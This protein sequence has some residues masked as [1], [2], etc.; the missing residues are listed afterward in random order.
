MS[1]SHGC[2]F[3]S[4]II[5]YDVYHNSNGCEDSCPFYVSIYQGVESFIASSFFEQNIA[6]AS[7]PWPSDFENRHFLVRS[8]VIILNTWHS[9]L[10]TPKILRSAFCKFNL[11]LLLTSVF[12]YVGDCSVSLVMPSTLHSGSKPT[13]STWC[14]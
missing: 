7:S 12:P 4:F 2:S 14:L 6:A 5:V 13:P 10:L 8:S 1:N 9:A 3:S 11:S